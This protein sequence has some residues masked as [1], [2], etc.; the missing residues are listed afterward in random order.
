MWGDLW[1]ELLWSPV[2]L[3]SMG[4]FGLIALAL[5]LMACAWFMRRGPR[6]TI[7]SRVPLPHVKIT[8][9]VSGFLFLGLLLTPLVLADVPNTFVN[10]QA[11]DAD[12]VN[13][14]FSHLDASIISKN[15]IYR[16]EDVRTDCSATLSCG[17]SA[18]C[19]DIDDVVIGGS[20]VLSCSGGDLACFDGN[21]WLGSGV[22]AQESTSPNPA[23]YFCTTK[24]VSGPVPLKV[25]ATAYCLALP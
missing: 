20:C 25:T 11:A 4:A 19:N 6:R 24:N 21:P 12:E 9:M 17:A 23:K 10:G 14:N 1:G 15:K 8:M 16:I 5:A 2:P 22:F 3:P 18:V 7:T 13:E